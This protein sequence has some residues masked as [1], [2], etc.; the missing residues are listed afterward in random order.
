MAAKKGLKQVW[1]VSVI[2]VEMDPN[3]PTFYP[4]LPGVVQ[5]DDAPQPAR[6]R[7]R[8]LGLGDAAE[9]R[10]ANSQD[11]G[12][13]LVRNN[14]ITL[15]WNTKTAALTYAKEQASRN[16][17]TAYGVFSCSDVFETTVPEIIEKQ[18]NEAGELIVKKSEVSNAG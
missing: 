15:G 8:G 4:E 2:G 6:P 12:F 17:K 16:P 10:I 1:F 7:D 13:T 5:Q 14:V 9:P 18:F 3:K 11:F